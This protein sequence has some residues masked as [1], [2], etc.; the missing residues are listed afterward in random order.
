MQCGGGPSRTGHQPVQGL[1]RRVAPAWGVQRRSLRHHDPSVFERT[2]GELIRLPERRQ[3]FQDQDEVVGFG[4]DL[5]DEGAGRM[6]GEGLGELAIE[7]HLAKIEQMCGTR[8]AAVRIGRWKL[9][10]H[11]GRRVGLDL[12]IGQAVT[13]A[14]ANK[15]VADRLAG[16]A[17]NLGPAYGASSPQRTVI[18]SWSI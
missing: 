12:L 4:I 16:H 9:A 13:I 3:V 6:D 1:Q 14:V 11:T 5:G 8:T 17:H 2:A 18:H 10:D 7:R 15:S